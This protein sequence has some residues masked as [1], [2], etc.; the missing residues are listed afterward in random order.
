[1][2]IFC[3]S[4]LL[5]WGRLVGKSL[6]RHFY[7]AAYREVSKKWESDLFGFPYTGRGLW[8]GNGLAVYGSV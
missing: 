4:C 3:F 1:M 5:L 2:Q 7:R 6:I 8:L